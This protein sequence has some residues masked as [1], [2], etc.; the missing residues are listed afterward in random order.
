LK[1]R[2]KRRPTLPFLRNQ[3]WD[4]F[5]VTAKHRSIV[6]LILPR[7]QFPPKLPLLALWHTNSMFA[8]QAETAVAYAV[9]MF[10]AFVLSFRQNWYFHAVVKRM[11]RLQFPPKL[12]RRSSSVCLKFK[13]SH[14][15]SRKV[16]LDMQNILE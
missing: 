9:Q 4:T 15:S 1:P 3:T 2:D 5:A 6:Q 13:R 11:A 10:S 12:L 7:V 14:A 8:A 16:K